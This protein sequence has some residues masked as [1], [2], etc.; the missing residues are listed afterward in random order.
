ML[1]S[2]LCFSYNFITFSIAPVKNW[3]VTGAVLSK[4]RYKVVLHFDTFLVLI[5]H[6]LFCFLHIFLFFAACGWAWKML[7]IFLYYQN[8]SQIVLILYCSNSYCL[9][10]TLKYFIAWSHIQR[11]L[12]W[13]TV[14]VHNRDH[15]GIFQNIIFQLKKFNFRDCFKLSDKVYL[16]YYFLVMLIISAKASHNMWW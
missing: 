3:K 10:C 11:Q 1:Q 12:S 15:P 2:F 4:I 5:L 14:V 7:I 9:F 16:Y 13:T 8:L 6:K